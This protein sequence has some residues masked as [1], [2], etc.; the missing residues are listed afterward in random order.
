M[1]LGLVGWDWVICPAPPPGGGI[2][3]ICGVAGIKH[4]GCAVA[5]RAPLQIAAPAAARRGKCAK[6]HCAKTRKDLSGTD[7][8]SILR[9]HGFFCQTN[10]SPARVDRLG[11]YTQSLHYEQLRQHTDAN[12]EGL[13][14]CLWVF[15]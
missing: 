13:C 10:Q 8:K 11:T 2:G 15:L 1:L 9:G 12:R 6:T 7:I 4:W 14:I 5:L 3:G